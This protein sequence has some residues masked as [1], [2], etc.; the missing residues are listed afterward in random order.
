M[1]RSSRLSTADSGRAQPSQPKNTKNQMQKT[2]VQPYLFFG[3]RCEEALEFYRKALGAQVDFLMRFKESPEPMP[4]D[5]LPVGYENK[6]MHSSFKI[7]ETALMASDGCEPDSKFAGFSLSISVA[8]E[9]E[10]ARVFAALGEGGQVH[11]PLAKTFWSPCFGILADRFG[12]SWMV[13]V[14]A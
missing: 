8:N 14:G 6:I 5:R 2:I 9:A 10:A 11:M 3:G 4:P 12:I 1:V 13:S 7:G